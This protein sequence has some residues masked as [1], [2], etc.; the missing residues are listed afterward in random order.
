MYIENK[1]SF[2]VMWRLGCKWVR[3]E[4]WSPEITIAGTTLKR[5]RKETIRSRL[6][7]LQ[8]G[9]RRLRWGRPRGDG[10]EEQSRDDD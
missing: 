1:I 10:R 7:G 2:T 4:A 8:R 9:L 6:D 3:V 5:L